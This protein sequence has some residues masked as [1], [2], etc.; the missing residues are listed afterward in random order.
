MSAVVITHPGRPRKLALLWIAP[1]QAASLFTVWAIT[2]GG[3]I[4][5]SWLLTATMCLM[6]L[7][8]LVGLEG[9]L[10]AMMLFEPLRGLLRRGQ[11]L[12]VDYT[13]QDPIHLL[14]PIV[15]FIALIALLRKERRSEE[16][17]VGK[18]CRSRRSA[19]Q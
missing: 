11:Y 12:I 9:T 15:T 1:M 8:L 16:R 10:L 17:R 18:E 3:E 2:A 4:L 14:T 5:R 13:A 7:P 6:T 19:C